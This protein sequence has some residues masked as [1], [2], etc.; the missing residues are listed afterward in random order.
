MDFQMWCQK[1][2]SKTDMRVGFFF[3]KVWVKGAGIAS[4][5]Y[6]D[7]FAASEIQAIFEVEVE[8]KRASKTYLSFSEACP[9]FL[10]A[11]GF[12]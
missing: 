2:E 6:V 7:T 10:E 1:K 8:L 4:S 3:F 9:N 11:L 5:L 12:H